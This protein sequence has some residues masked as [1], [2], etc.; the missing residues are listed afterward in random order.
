MPINFHDSTNKYSY[1]AR[2]A[3]SRWI[4]LIWDFSAIQ[5]KAVLDLGCGGGIYTRALALAGAR[6][7]TGMDFSAEMLQGAEADCRGISN[8]SFRQGSA[9]NIPQPAESYDLLLQRA[10]IHHISELDVCFREAWRVLRPRGRLFVQDRTPEDCALPGS[11]GHLRGYFFEKYPLLLT[12]EQARR[13][14]AERVAGELTAAGFEI[15]AE[16]KIWEHRRSYRHFGE[17][18]AELLQRQGRSILHELTD[19]ELS[20]LADHMEE[21][22]GSGGPIE[23]QDRWTMWVAEKR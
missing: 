9:L 7:V 15:I 13:H 17:L 23:E 2:T 21:R 6:Q 14:P 11:A 22:L 18:R 5:G 8:L 4:Q 12:Q 10:L 20:E 19:V 3:D 1:T 16:L